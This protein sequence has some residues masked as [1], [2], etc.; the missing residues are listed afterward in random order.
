MPSQKT[1]KKNEYS[2]YQHIQLKMK[3]EINQVLFLQ[4]THKN[5]VEKR[6]ISTFHTEEI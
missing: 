3:K 4:R 2:K 1:L 5:R 6:G